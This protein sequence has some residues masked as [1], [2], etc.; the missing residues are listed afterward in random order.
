MKEIKHKLLTHRPLGEVLDDMR[1][2]ANRHQQAVNGELV[3]RM[4]DIGADYERMRDFV[5]RGYQDDKREEVYN[6]LRRRT[7]RLACDWELSV[8]CSQPTG[9]YHDAARLTASAIICR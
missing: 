9:F 6:S 3:M 1:Q 7:Y 8:L 4:V 5:L 2:F